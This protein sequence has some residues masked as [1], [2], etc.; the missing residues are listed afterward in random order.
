MQAY[1]KSNVLSVARC[2]GYAWLYVS[3]FCCALIC[4]SALRGVEAPAV[5]RDWCVARS[6]HRCSCAYLLPEGMHAIDR[7]CWHYKRRKRCSC[8]ATRCNLTSHGT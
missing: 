8:G 4:F 3:L 1:W 6:L 7:R 2:G 5:A